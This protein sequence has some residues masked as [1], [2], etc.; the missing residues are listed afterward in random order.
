MAITDKL[1]VNLQDIE[2]RISEF[3]KNI[4]PK[5]LKYTTLAQ[6]DMQ[7]RSILGDKLYFDI[8]DGFDP[9]TGTVAT[10]YEDLYE[11]IKQHLIARVCERSIY[12]IHN[13]I[14]N[15]GIQNRNSDYSSNSNETTVFR[16]MNIYKKDAEFYE[17]RLWNHLRDNKAD[18]PLWKEKSDDINP[19]KPDSDFGF[20]II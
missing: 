7:T 12:I 5:Q 14:T 10:I 6:Q 3:D 9:Q 16:T 19:Q 17:N 15:K 8:L 20:F 11:F 4:S 1:L 13:Q 2:E 18:Y